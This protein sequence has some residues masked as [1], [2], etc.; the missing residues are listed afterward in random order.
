MLVDDDVLNVLA[1]DGA[2]TAA[3]RP[4]RS[5]CSATRRSSAGRSRWSTRTE[6]RDTG[7][8]QAHLRGGRLAGWHTVA[9]LIEQCVRA[10]EAGERFVYAYYP[11]VDTIA[12]EFGLH[13]SAFT[14]ELG[15]RRPPR[16]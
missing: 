6:F 1:L 4:I 5:T 16:R 2:R 12:H 14:R 3:A 8:T 7:F 13:D 15:V 10:V 11:G 9:G